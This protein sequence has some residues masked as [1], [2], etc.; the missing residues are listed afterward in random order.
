[1][2]LVKREDRMNNSMNRELL[3]ELTLRYRAARAAHPATPA[4]DIAE[5]ISADLPGGQIVT[6]AAAQLGMADEQP[7]RGGHRVDSSVQAFLLN[8][9]DEMDFLTKSVGRE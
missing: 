8:F 3:N 6:L 4:Q 5:L 9:V 7:I 1:M 2:D